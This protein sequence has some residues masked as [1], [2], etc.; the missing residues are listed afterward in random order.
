[1]SAGRGVSGVVRDLVGA[2]G[3]A[4]RSIVV[5]AATMCAL[6]LAIAVPTTVSADRQV[7]NATRLTTM[8][9]PAV[10][11]NVLIRTSVS[12]SFSI[13]RGE[14]AAAPGGDLHASLS[15]ELSTEA[16]SG[17][18]RAER[19]ADGAL[20]R[21]DGIVATDEYA[22][23][24]LTRQVM[25][26]LVD[27]QRDAMDRWW[28]WTRSERLDAE[29]G[30]RAYT[31][32]LAAN[33]RVGEALQDDRAHLREATRVGSL[34]IT[35]IVLAATAI[36]FVLA[37]LVSILTVRSLTGPI[38]TL[39]H[40]VRR[41]RAGDRGAYARVD[42][43]ARELRELAA[44]VNALTAAHLRLR[45]EQ[46]MRLAF[47]RAETQLARRLR[48]VSSR[49]DA[50]DITVRALARR[51]P[52]D[53]CVGLLL[54]E[55]H[56]PVEWAQAHGRPGDVA[57]LDDD[58]LAEVVHHLI[59]DEDALDV[60]DLAE[61]ETAADVVTIDAAE[62]SMLV[63]PIGLAGGAIGLLIVHDRRDRDAWR[64]AEVGFLEGAAEVLARVVVQQEVDTAREQHVRNLEEL[65]RQKDV[66][67]STVSHE[68]RTPLTSIRGYLE[69]L[70]DG[71][72]GDLTDG[73]VRMLGIVDRNAARLRGLIEDLLV[74]TRLQTDGASGERDIV[75]VSGLLRDTAAE[76]A[77][78]AIRAGIHV[79]VHTDEEIP[80][81]GHRD[82]L[83]RAFS[84]VVANAVKFTPSGG[85]VDLH[86]VLDAQARAV[87]IV[88]EDTGIGIPAEDLPRMSERFYRAS[89]A[90]D[91]QIP[92][93]GL[94]LSI[95]R[96]I[97]ENHGGD[98]HLDSTH[99][100]GTTVTFTLPATT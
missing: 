81:R 15:G 82:D 77:P 68:L 47:E 17:L 9:G 98:L 96:A 4:K 36:A 11:A 45:D 32:A 56:R 69:M 55:H 48:E 40:A 25:D 64:E 52:A 67:L 89:N 73:Q 10:D 21:L 18:E 79:T 28:S 34:N 65:D 2:R 97:V 41:Q 31:A 22:D 49:L 62:G 57:R 78:E 19:A 95:V 33:G 58:D 99:G 76:L 94:G 38:D 8:V 92:G 63:V 7:Q 37:V 51:L 75:D 90:A 86:A 44:D 16:A 74:V 88:C 84:N 85:K 27:E 35:T 61:G 66:F 50:V 43:G 12:D 29:E 80:V 93:T 53:H 71:D 70:I 72:A 23:S 3:S 30:V 59:T 6:M 1:M 54:D 46:D 39:R 42:H 91:A 87:R 14:A 13:L 83:A 5:F 60:D 24:A 100:E 20:T 26:E